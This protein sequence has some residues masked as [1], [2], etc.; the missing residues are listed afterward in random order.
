[1][2]NLPVYCWH[3]S[4]IWIFLK[5]TGHYLCNNPLRVAVLTCYVI[6]DFTRK[7][8]EYGWGQQVTVRLWRIF[9]DDSLYVIRI[10]ISYW[11]EWS[12]FQLHMLKCSWVMMGSTISWNGSEQTGPNSH[13]ILWNELDK[14]DVTWGAQLLPITQATMIILPPWY[15]TVTII[16]K[17]FTICT[18]WQR[19][20]FIISSYI[21]T[22]VWRLTETC[23]K[24]T[25]VQCGRRSEGETSSCKAKWSM[26]QLSC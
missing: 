12:L 25:W 10:A 20:V 19:I 8:T 14:L 16:P 11:V 15:P 2:L 9:N 21:I 7:F 4:K 26:F 23:G 3:I 13:T 18:Q 17:P 22:W 5:Y 6:F 1:M 24:S